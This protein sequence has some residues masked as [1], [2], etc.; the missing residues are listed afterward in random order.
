M[1]LALSESRSRE[2]TPLPAHEPATAP[3]PGKY[4]LVAELARGGMGNVYLVVVQG[5]GGFN[6]LLA[7]K[8]LKPELSDDP[9]YV[10]MFLDE[11]R[12][13]ARLNHPNIV[14]TNEVGS[15]GSR[16]Y[17]TMEYL[18]G[19]SLHRIRRRFVDQG[20]FPV[21]AHLRIIAES[22]LGLHY[23]H[24]LVGFDGEPLGIVHRDVS[25]LNVFVTFDGQAKVLDFGIAKTVDSSHETKAGV[26]KGRVAYMAPEQ[27]CGAKAD[28]RA[29]IY[30]AGVMIWEAAAGRRLW[31][32]MS[33]VEVLSRLLREG[34]PS[35][36]TVCPDAPEE[37]EAICSRAMAAHPG[38]RYDTA[39]ELYEDLE[40]HI[41]Q[42]EDATSMRQIGAFIGRT[43]AEERRQMKAAIEETLARARG[44]NPSGVLPV[45]ALLRR[46]IS[47]SF[48]AS[49]AP[50]RISSNAPFH[51]PAS[52]GQPNRDIVSE[53]PLTSATSVSPSATEQAHSGRWARLGLP[54]AMLCAGAAVGSVIAFAIV[55]H[56]AL[57]GHPAAVRPTPTVA[58]APMV[59]VASPDLVDISVR[60]TP[61]SSRITVD[62]ASIANNPF[63][64]RYPK[65]NQIHHIAATADGYEPKLEDVLFSGDVSIDISLD[66]RAPLPQRKGFGQPR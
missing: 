54:A 2:S 46:P 49:A 22:L 32:G 31:P 65:D 34:P 56:I 26:L 16:H 6:K 30:S 44:T 62:G 14:Q 20:R 55:P 53:M 60:V 52:V 63:R 38:D 4:H 36:R 11:A 12:L 39:A 15:E 41:N 1:T 64:G 3:G 43:F 13:A 37:L 27:A 66:R 35:L 42:R 9:S 17:M 47:G 28:R 23:A 25:P 33:E 59:F 61:P 58:L 8:E 10:S 45:S 51:P 48:P 21:G 57:R 29:D 24:D 18:D 7:L 5:P 40:A 50:S 19:R